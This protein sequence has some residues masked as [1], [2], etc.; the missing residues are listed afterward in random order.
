M[1]NVMRKIRSKTPGGKLYIDVSSIK[2]EQ[3]SIVV[4]SKL[5]T[6]SHPILYSL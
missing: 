6:Y 3:V 4:R 1:K 5:T 2:R